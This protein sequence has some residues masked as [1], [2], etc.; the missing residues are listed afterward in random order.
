MLLIRY[1]EFLIEMPSKRN[2]LN[3]DVPLN[4]NT[5]A[6]RFNTTKDFKQLEDI[7]HADIKIKLGAMIKPGRHKDSIMQASQ[8][9]LCS[10]ISEP[11]W[12]QRKVRLM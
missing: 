11:L 8:T 12:A 4:H 1:Q 9:P 2:L 10:F 5:S 3:I 7:L 6:T